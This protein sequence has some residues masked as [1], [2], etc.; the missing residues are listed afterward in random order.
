MQ[1]PHPANPSG[2]GP[3]SAAPGP[4]LQAF[5]HRDDEQARPLFEAFEQGFRH[6]EMDVWHVFGRT[7]VAHDPQDLRPWNTLQR[8][9]LD[10][11][12]T[13]HED[14]AISGGDPIW[15]FVDTKTRAHPMHG[16]LERLAHAYR[17][18]VA[19]PTNPADERPVR[20]LLTGN[21]P[22]Y[23]RLERTPDRRTAL[24][25]RLSDVGVRTDPTMMPVVSDHWRKHFTWRGQGAMP[26]EE[27]ARLRG[28]V[29]ALRVSGQRLR[30]WETPDAPGPE[31]EALWATLLDEGV[32]L[33]NTDDV[34]GLA[35]FLRRRA[36]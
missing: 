14:R 6:I 25:G 33:I 15:L 13:L 20:L 18:V 24:D 17:D 23:E 27:R 8:L 10:P 12:R 21:R 1:R 32:D 26:E 3:T 31:R 2:G 5:S 34:H 22:S 19:D 30:F 35:A 16:A 29:A 36:G 4:I 7:L 28:Q 9:Y 11:L